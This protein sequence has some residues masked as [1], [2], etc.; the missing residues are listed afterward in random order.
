M[1]NLP[2]VAPQSLLDLGCGYGAIGL[3]LAA[4]H[5]AA[6]ALLVDRDLLAVRAA[7][8]NARTL[9]LG[10]VEV[11]P[12]LG[13]RDVPASLRFDLVLCNVPARIGP[14]AIAYFLDAGRALA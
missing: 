7:A 8:H 4:R 5:P 12:S 6:R 9:G 1:R 2:D 14:R 3:T 11:R 13:Y 10:N